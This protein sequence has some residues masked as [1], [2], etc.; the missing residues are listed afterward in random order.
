MITVNAAGEIVLQSLTRAASFQLTATSITTAP[1]SGSVGVSA[2][3]QLLAGVSLYQV[4]P[5][6]TYLAG[7]GVALP[8]ASVGAQVNLVQSAT[9]FVSYTPYSQTGAFIN[10]DSSTASLVVNSRSVRC[11]A[12]STTRWN[13]V[14]DFYQ[15]QNVKRVETATTSATL[16]VDQSGV[17]FY[18]AGTSAITFTLPSCASS[19]IGV[20]YDF[21]LRPN[22]ITATT[23]NLA[24]SGSDTISGVKVPV[25]SS[26]GVVSIAGTS[27]GTG[28]TAFTAI[29]TNS[30]TAGN[31]NGAFTVTCVA[32][33]I[34]QAVGIYASSN[35]A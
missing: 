21:S 20:Y 18:Y 33:G 3:A 14:Q 15:A 25:S 28:S 5:A 4:V 30:V 11:V 10:A 17:L 24:S 19:S 16:T 31:S 8:A 1:T 13:C 34:W 22:A 6:T 35:I 27:S 32:S 7:Q 26:V 12:V 23:F 9:T 2:A 29:V